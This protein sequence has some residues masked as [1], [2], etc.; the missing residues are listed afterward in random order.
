MS[1]ERERRAVDPVFVG[2]ES[3]R[4]ESS[5]Y[6]QY[7]EVCCKWKCSCASLTVLLQA[8]DYDII[9]NEP[10]KAEQK[11]A[12]WLYLKIRPALQFL[13]TLAIGLIVA[14]IGFFVVYESNAIVLLHCVYICL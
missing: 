9:E 14:C 1:L 11:E 2:T 10:Y 12:T 5:P 3:Q 13:I 4:Y 6:Q 7:Y 8:L